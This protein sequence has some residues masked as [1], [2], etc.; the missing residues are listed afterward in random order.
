MSSRSTAIGDRRQF[1]DIQ[2]DRPNPVLGDRSALRQNDGDWLAD[3]T[4]GI[5]GDPR[6]K[7]PLGPWQWEEAQ[8]DGRHRADLRRRDDGPNAGNNAR[9]SRV[10]AANSAMRDRAA[11]DRCVQ[12]SFALQ[13]PD[14]L[15]SAAQKPQI[16]G[17]LDR[18][19]DITVRPDHGLLVFR[20][21]ARASSTASTIGM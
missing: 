4:H 15:A 8:R 13:I 9:R 19:A 20:Y 12:H 17:P 6:L 5:G 10:E 1:F 7:E 11:Q 18:A 3:I 21:A 2:D 16:L 14:K